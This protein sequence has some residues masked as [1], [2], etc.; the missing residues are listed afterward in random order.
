M[1]LL[2]ASAVV[3][4]ANSVALAADCSLCGEES[5]DRGSCPH[6]DYEG[7]GEKIGYYGSKMKSKGTPLT[8]SD[9][10]YI[11]QIADNAKNKGEV[12]RNF[13]KIKTSPIVSFATPTGDT[14]GSTDT[15][16][17]ISYDNNWSNTDRVTDKYRHKDKGNIHDNAIGRY[18]V[19][20]ISN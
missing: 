18:T 19:F 9:K 20:A 8:E 17:T 1:K 5:H 15:G 10:N 14:S 13:L 4:G 16:S 7:Y 2:S 12:L 6:F 3:A 11:G